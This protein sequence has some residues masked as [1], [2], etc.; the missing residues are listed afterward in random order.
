MRAREETLTMRRFTAGIAAAL[1]L[2][3]AAATGTAG[4]ASKAAQ[5]SQTRATYL[6][7]QARIADRVDD[8]LGRMTLQ[9]KIGQMDQIVVG[10]LRGPSN[11]SDGNCNGGDS[12]PPQTSC[13]PKVLIT[14]KTRPLPPRG[15][16][17][18]PHK[19]GQ[20]GGGP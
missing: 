4:A 14:H 7:P 17:N 13:L 20:G 18:P 5:R 10:K 16:G 12:D 19:T 1:L 9:E 11:P 15:N 2:A 3:A 6:N 8:L